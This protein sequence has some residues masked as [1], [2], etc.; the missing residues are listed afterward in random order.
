MS[1]EVGLALFK[2]PSVFD[3]AQVSHE[4]TPEAAR[5][6]GAASGLTGDRLQSLEQLRMHGSGGS[7]RR[8]HGLGNTRWYLAEDI[9]PGVQ[10][11]GQSFTHRIGCADFGSPPARAGAPEPE[12]P[13]AHEPLPRGQPRAR[14]GDRRGTGCKV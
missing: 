5:I 4:I 1:H 13:E 8:L 7:I 10:H 12:K 11:R 6:D 3:S 9:G 2:P 14:S